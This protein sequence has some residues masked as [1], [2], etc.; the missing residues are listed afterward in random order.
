MAPHRAMELGV[1]LVP[2]DRHRDGAI[3]S[4]SLTDNVTSVTL[5][6]YFRVLLLNRRRM[7]SDA[8][9]LAAEFD[10]RPKDPE[11]DYIM[12]SGGNQQKAL[13]AKWLQLSP[14]VLLLH[15]PTQGVDV[16]ARQ[17]IFQLLRAARGSRVTICASSDHEQL[18]AI[19]DRVLVF[20][21][22]HIV[23]ELQGSDVTEDR[24][25]QECLMSTVIEPAAS[26]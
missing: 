10:V 12:F 11:L 26:A 3:S 14:R 5:G 7:R 8:T 2:A 13:L 4:L 1:A 19:C 21:H 24:I 15:E 6:R 20:G 23:S 22:G 17:Q 9:R 25:T 18:A 16:G